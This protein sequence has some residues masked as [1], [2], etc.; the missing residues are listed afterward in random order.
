[1]PTRGGTRPSQADLLVQMLQDARVRG[2]ALAARNR[3]SGFVIHSETQ[4]HE[5]TSC[6][7]DAGS[8]MTP[9]G[10]GQTGSLRRL[11]NEPI[12]TMVQVLCSTVAGRP[13][14][15]VHDT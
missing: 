7:H 8:A 13:K 9:S 11:A 15:Q 12:R 10:F 5:M 3:G 6:F 14:S 2:V 1:M 4:G